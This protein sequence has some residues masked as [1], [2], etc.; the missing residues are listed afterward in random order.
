MKFYFYN[1]NIST[2]LRNYYCIAIAFASR[3]RFSF[4]NLVHTVLVFIKFFAFKR[5]SASAA[6]E[7]FALFFEVTSNAFFPK[8]DVFA[9]SPIPHEMEFAIFKPAKP[10]I[11]RGLFAERLPQILCRQAAFAWIIKRMANAVAAFIETSIARTFKAAQFFRQTVRAR[12]LR[13]L[14]TPII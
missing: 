4:S 1:L 8:T 12:L 13:L 11:I 3:L 7:F 2:L 5:V 6:F 10:I 9:S 14:K